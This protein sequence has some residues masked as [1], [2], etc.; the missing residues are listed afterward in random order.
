[1]PLIQVIVLGLVQGVTEFL[2]VS[3]S[4]HLYLVS[5]YAGWPDQGLTFDVALHLGTLIAILIYFAGTWI[6]ILLNNRRML[7]FLIVGTIPGAIIGK[8]FEKRIEE[9]LRNPWTIGVNFILIALVMLWAERVSRQTRDLHSANMLDAIGIGCA[10]ALAVMPGVSRSGVTIS[11]G[12]FREFNREAAA[13]FSFLLATPLIAGAALVRGLELR[14]TG[15][16]ADMRMPFL[17]G[18]GIAAV[19]GFAVIAFFLR[20]LQTRTLKI[21]IYYRIVF[22]IIVLLLAIFSRPR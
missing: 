17:L 2:P 20:Y 11:G 15:I 8:L 21:F 18:M 1:M 13:R 12:L 4:A 6:D 3:S 16:P 19:S 14:H 5:L 22:G 10:Q 9:S 7:G